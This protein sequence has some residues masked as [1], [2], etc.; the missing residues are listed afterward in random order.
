[1]LV[2]TPAVV[3]CDGDFAAGACAGFAFKSTTGGGRFAAVVA[4]AG[5]AGAATGAA[6]AA[7]RVAT[8][9]VV[10]RV[11]VRTGAGA[12]FAVACAV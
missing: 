3:G 4:G 8:W 11:A 12:G 5:G 7:A 1:M 10:T 6:G 2:L 9:L